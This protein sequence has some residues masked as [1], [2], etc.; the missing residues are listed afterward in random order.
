MAIDVDCVFQLFVLWVRR[1]EDLPNS[2]GTAVDLDTWILTLLKKNVSF[3][4]MII[5]SYSL[6]TTL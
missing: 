3:L 2:N 6:C 1:L 4:F 5:V